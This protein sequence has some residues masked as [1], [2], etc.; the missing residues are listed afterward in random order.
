MV[1]RFVLAVL[2]LTLLALGIITSATE[3]QSSSWIEARAQG[4]SLILRHIPLSQPL[5][6]N[7]TGSK[8]RFGAI[9]AALIYVSFLL[10]LVN[11]T[12][13]QKNVTKRRAP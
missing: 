7:S 12:V 10:G 11:V 5:S 9:G 2:L 6:E 8:Y 4:S 13:I 1:N 3:A